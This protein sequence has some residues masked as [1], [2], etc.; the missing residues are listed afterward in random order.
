MAVFVPTG[1]RLKKNEIRSSPNKDPNQSNQQ[2]SQE[3]TPQVALYHSREE[4]PF[5]VILESVYPNNMITKC[6][7]VKLASFMDHHLNKTDGE[8]ARRINADRKSTRLNSSHGGISRM[9]SSA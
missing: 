4:G 6:N 1:K 9:P 8:L 5:Q 7:F 2:P 3:N